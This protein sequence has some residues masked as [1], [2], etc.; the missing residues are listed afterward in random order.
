M[1]RWLDVDGWIKRLIDQQVH[2]EAKKKN[3]RLIVE[4][5]G[6]GEY[7]GIHSTILSIFKMC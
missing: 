1:A 4:F 3:K 2:Y 5:G 7:I 6:W